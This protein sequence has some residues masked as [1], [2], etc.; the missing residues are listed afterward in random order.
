MR[1]RLIQFAG[2]FAR[3]V[4]PNLSQQAV[5]LAA[6]EAIA[7]LP[8]PELGRVAIENRDLQLVFRHDCLCV[9][10][11][12]QCPV[13]STSGRCMSGNMCNAQAL[14]HWACLFAIQDATLHQLL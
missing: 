3:R 2:A 7:S 4:K 8:P 12:V 6:A 13:P 14:G 5:Q 1:V 10:G 11:P 9:P